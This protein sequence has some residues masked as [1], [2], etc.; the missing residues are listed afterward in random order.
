MY[1]YFVDGALPKPGLNCYPE[2]PPFGSARH[3]E[4]T[5]FAQLEADEDLLR[6]IDV[7]GAIVGDLRVS[8]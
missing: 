1:S 8:M 4:M 7:I 2:A 6:S 3:P 5:T